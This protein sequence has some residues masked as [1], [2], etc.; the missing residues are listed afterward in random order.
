MYDLV[1]KGGII[2]DGTGGE[3]FVSDV[4]VKDGRIV[5]VSRSIDGE[6]FNT[7][8][9]NGLHVTPGF[10]D[11]HC[12]SEVYGLKDPYMKHRIG[13]GI[14][15]DLCGNC[16]IGLFP[17]NEYKEW[18]YPLNNDVLGHYDSYT[19]SDFSSYR[20]LLEGRMGINQAYLV[21]HAPLRVAVLGPECGR[22]A[23]ENEIKAMCSLLETALDQGCKGLSS[24]L[25]YS[26]CSSARRDELLTLLKTVASRDK[27][28]C[29]HHRI[30]GPGIIGS[31]REV[32][33]LAL[34]TGVRLEISHLKII[35]KKYGYLLDDIFALIDEY[36]GKGV[37]V[38][39]DQYPYHYGSTSLFSLLPAHVLALS[40]CEQ[41]RVLKDEAKRRLIKDE[42]LHPDGWESLYP[43][44]GPDD[45][46][47]LALDH[48][49]AYD[50]L[51]LSE[52]G[53]VLGKDPLDAMLDLLSDEDGAAVMIDITESEDT[54]RR[55]LAHPLMCF[56][57]DS[58]YSTPD[59]H[60]R[61]FS[62]SIHMLEDY[63][64][65]DNVISFPE[66]IRKMTHECASRLG[67]DDLGLIKEGCRADICL[68][69]LKNLHADV[70]Q[71]RGLEYVIVN[72]SVAYEKGVYKD[73]LT[74]EIK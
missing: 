63:V 7:I 25:Y 69:D 50:G 28:F 6:A 41:E 31:V 65:R 11:F 36:I 58:L 33:E 19:W 35:G 52:V 64:L 38:K 24:G 22:A 71:N 44:V 55:I 43:V 16:G 60:P 37:R 49:K 8:A 62:A 3:P 34:E 70:K 42:M 68:L 14:T 74:G 9:A 18:L 48:T 27:L 56:G 46:S 32:L 73:T 57:T 15:T 59:P 17:A 47:V 5:S 61:S 40:R 67:L 26:P 21:S 29:V 53:R 1:I 10:I 30:E 39:F 54:L 45:I 4:A 23:D 20:K 66:A 12:H 2:T 51:S 72:G 13:Q